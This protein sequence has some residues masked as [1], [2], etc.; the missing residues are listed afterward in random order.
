MT[1]L[2]GEIDSLKQIRNELTKKGIS[3]FSS[4]SEIKTFIKNYE[5]ERNKIESDTIAEFE[6]EIKQV[7]SSKIE[8]E[9]IY[10]ELNEIENTR[11]NKTLASLKIRL[12]LLEQDSKNLI[13][14]IIQTIRR[15]ILQNWS[16]YLEKNHKKLIVK[17]TSIV[18]KNID[19]VNRK[20]NFITSNRL[21]EI[22]KRIAEKTHEV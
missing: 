16:S 3:R 13:G 7:E 12:S 20:L 6:S 10:E 14:E 11:I 8:L 15:T 22:N 4:V 9:K 21:D 17:R 1:I 2:K 5:T 18:T 19:N